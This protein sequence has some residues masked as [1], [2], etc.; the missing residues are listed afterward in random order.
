MANSDYIFGNKGLD[1]IV[2]DQHLYEDDDL[3]AWASSLLKM[4]SFLLDGTTIKFFINPV[5]V[6]KQFT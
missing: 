2:N 4:L 6:I 5:K 3:V 1:R